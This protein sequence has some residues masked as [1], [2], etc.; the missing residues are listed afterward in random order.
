MVQLRWLPP[1]LSE[2]A[3]E[4]RN[5]EEFTS[6]RSGRVRNPERLPCCGG[7]GGVTIKPRLAAAC[8]L[9]PGGDIDFCSAWL[10][11][12]ET[13]VPCSH[14][15]FSHRS[16]EKEF[17]NPTQI[18]R[19]LTPF[20]MTACWAGSSQSVH[21]GIPHQHLLTGKLGCVHMF[22]SDNTQQE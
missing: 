12:Q 18:S 8:L 16:P 14:A 21:I 1:D 11:S 3:R 6:C 2:S 15:G 9:A 19:C 10:L 7:V 4:M 17:L 20:L 22:Q 13:D 5:I